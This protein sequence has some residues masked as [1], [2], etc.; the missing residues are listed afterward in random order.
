ME[1]R[2]DEK[3]GVA[4]ERKPP[5]ADGLFGAADA[6]PFG[7]PLN[8]DRVEKEMRGREA[9]VERATKRIMEEEGVKGGE[10]RTRALDEFEEK[11]RAAAVG[12]GPVLWV[13]RMR[14]AQHLLCVGD[15]DALGAFREVLLGHVASHGE[16]WKAAVLD[17]RKQETLATDE[18]GVRAWRMRVRGSWGD[19]R[20]L[21][22]VENPATQEALS[23][24]VQFIRALQGTHEDRVHL[25]VLTST[26]AAIPSVL[27]RYLGFRVCFKT[28]AMNS[29][30][31]VGDESAATL[32]R[33]ASM[34]HAAVVY[35]E[36]LA[37]HPE[38][39]VYYRVDLP[40]QR[41]G[42]RLDVHVGVPLMGGEGD[43]EAR[44]GR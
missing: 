36:W 3:D 32:P 43:D 11:V 44:G 15:L 18:E 20:M 30:D 22:V 7:E 37:E 41:H 4:M 42:R 35:E 29:R 17:R 24:L 9:F 10:A 27:L 25:A 23:A 28:N 5:L 26:P 34:P 16:A 14:G 8:R 1:K 39:G 2:G 21:V 12:G 38:H 33:F 13:A 6:I 19:T 40:G 31:V